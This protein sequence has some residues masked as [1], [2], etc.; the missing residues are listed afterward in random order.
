MRYTED[1][2]PAAI[3]RCQHIKVNGVQCGSPALNSRKYCYFHQKWHESGIESKQ[4]LDGGHYFSQHTPLLE[5]ANSI[6][7]ALTEIMFRISTRQID[8]KRAGLLLYALQTASANLP[9][10]RFEPSPTEVVIQPSRVRDTALGDDAWYKEEFIDDDESDDEEDDEEAVVEAAAEA[11]DD[12][13]PK[14]NSAAGDK[15]S[16]DPRKP[17]PP[18]R[19]ASRR[20]SKLPPRIEDWAADQAMEG[21]QTALTIMDDEESR[22]ELRPQ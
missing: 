6:Q 20:R 3:R 10:T 14:A 8:D 1:L 13:E 2:F 5:D 21:L 12:A 7:V 18:A 19:A 22:A 17:K 9:R 11:D 16:I 15:P 4:I